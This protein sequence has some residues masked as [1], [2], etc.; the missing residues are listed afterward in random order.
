MLFRRCLDWLNYWGS[1]L[2]DLVLILTLIPFLVQLLKLFFFS[3]ENVR[4]NELDE[5]IIENLKN[6]SREHIQ[7]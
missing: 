2:S 1:D 4:W 6:L 5:F 3:L 7:L